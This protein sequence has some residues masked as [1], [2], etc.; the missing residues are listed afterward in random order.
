M[1]ADMGRDHGSMGTDKMSIGKMSSVM[2]HVCAPPEPNQ[3][4]VPGDEL[5]KQGPRNPPD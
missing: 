4:W 2:N 5:A 3:L 1:D